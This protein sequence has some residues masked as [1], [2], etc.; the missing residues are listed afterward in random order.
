MAAPAA[1]RGCKST[2]WSDADLEVREPGDGDRSIHLRIAYSPERPALELI[3]AVV[4]TPWAPDRVGLHHLAF[5]A[6]ELVAESE[7]L[8]GTC[9]I[10]IC[11]RDAG[12]NVPTTFTY[13]T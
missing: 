2:T 8:A 9:P 5:F 1:R 12:G 7:R 4:G 13:H 6:D 3:E 11:G 10:E